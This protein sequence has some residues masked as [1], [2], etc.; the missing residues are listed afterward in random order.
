MCISWS[1]NLEHFKN[2]ILVELVFFVFSYLVL[3]IWNYDSGKACTGF[4][5][6]AWKTWNT[7]QNLDKLG[8][9]QEQSSQH[10][11]CGTAWDSECSEEMPWLSSTICPPTLTVPTNLTEEDISHFFSPITVYTHFQTLEREV[12]ERKMTM[13]FVLMLPFTQDMLSNRTRQGPGFCTLTS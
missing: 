9:L 4:A 3:H 2:C 7:E 12:K 8:T 10:D 11:T 5:G 13:A 6:S 1:Q